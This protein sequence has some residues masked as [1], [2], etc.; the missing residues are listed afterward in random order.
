MNYWI[1]EQTFFRKKKCLK[2]NE[3]ASHKVVT[4]GSDSSDS[5]N[6]YDLFPAAAENAAKN[7]GLTDVPIDDEPLKKNRIET[8]DNNSYWLLMG[9]NCKPS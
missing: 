3:K 1:K 8:K 7:C 5:A 2:L 6:W 9:K 4:S